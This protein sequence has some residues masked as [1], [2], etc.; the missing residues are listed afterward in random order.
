MSQKWN[1]IVC[2]QVY[3]CHWKFNELNEVCEWLRLFIFNV[4]FDEEDRKL[5]AFASFNEN[6]RTMYGVQCTL[7]YIVCDVREI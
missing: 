1:A 3:L 6:V 5:S 4:L 7:V 2:N